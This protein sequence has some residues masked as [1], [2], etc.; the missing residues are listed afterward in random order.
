MLKINQPVSEFEGTCP[1]AW[2]GDELNPPINAKPIGDDS[3]G[4]MVWYHPKKNTS[5]NKIVYLVPKKFGRHLIS[6][7]PDRWK[8]LG[9]EKF[10]VRM[11]E[12]GVFVWKDF[13]PWEW[14]LISTE[15]D[16]K[17]PGEYIET[18]GWVE[19]KKAQ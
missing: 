10:T 7:Q 16:T 15:E 2:V 19:N 1:V 4:E 14:K 9:D 13:Y 17:K 18:F 11:Q 3:S 12:D 5:I 6:T 8:L